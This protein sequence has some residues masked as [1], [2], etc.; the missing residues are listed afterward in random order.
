[1]QFHAGLQAL[2]AQGHRV[3]LEIGPTP[4]LSALGGKIA[5]DEARWLPSLRKGRPDWAQML[6]SLAALYEHGVTVN[7]AGFDRDY[8]RRR[9]SLPTYPFQRERHWMER[10][11]TPQATPATPAA[12]GASEDWLYEVRWRPAP[13]LRAA[14]T[15]LPSPAELAARV[16]GS[17]S[18]LRDPHGL[19]VYDEFLPALD[20][21]CVSYVTTAWRTL[22]WRPQLGQ[23]L[24]VTTLQETLGIVDAHCR[25]LGR[26]LEI[27]GEAGLLRRHGDAWEVVRIPAEEEPD[28]VAAGLLARFPSV[29]AEL[30][31]TRRCASQLPAVLR[32]A[33]DPLELLFPGGSL[34]MAER[35]Y[36]QA[37]AARAFNTLVSEVVRAAANGMAGQRPLRVL[38]I[39]AGTGGTTWHLLQAL[40]PDTEYVFTDVSP[41]FV[42]RAQEKFRDFPSV[43]YRSLDIERSPA[44]QGLAG[45]TFDIVVAANVLHATRDL[46]RTLSHAHRL[47]APGGL[48]VLLEA[49]ARQRFADLTV[50]LTDGWWRFTDTD[51]RP[52]Y[53]L[54]SRERWLALLDESGFVDSVALP[55]AAAADGGVLSQQSVLVS[56]APLGDAGRGAVPRPAAQAGQTWLVFADLGG[57]G[58]ALANR[59]RQRGERCVMITRG[60]R[61]KTLAPDL[62]QLAPGRPEDVTQL[63][64]EL[65]RPGQRA[66]RG[67]VH[68]W[69]LDAPLGE[70]LGAAELAEVQAAVCGTS[71]DVTRALVTAPGAAGSRLWLVTRGA[72][73]GDR[74]VG[75]MALAQ[76]PLWGLGRVI[77]LE[78]PEL[79]CVRID[80][81]PAAPDGE[82][83]ALLDEL[84][85]EAS[86]PEIALRAGGRLV[87]RLVRSPRG[88]QAPGAVDDPGLRP[89]A[90]YLITGGCGG[91]GLLVAR[92]MVDHGARHLVLVG[93]RPPTPEAQATID[94]MLAA[95]AEVRVRHADVARAE[96]MAGVLSEITRTMP[97]LHG[98]IH[99]AGVLD[100]GALLQQDWPRFARVL[101]PKVEGAWNLHTLTREMPLDFFILFSS[102]ASLL[103][104][105]GQ[106]NH[107][108]ANAFLDALAHHRRAQGQPAMSIGWGP[109]ADVGAW[110]RRRSDRPAAV[111]GEATI[112]PRAGLQILG[113]LMRRNPTQVGV[114]PVDWSVPSAGSERRAAFLAELLSPSRHQAR[115]VP[116]PSGPGIRQQILEAPA[117]TRWN[118]LH[119]LVRA[120]TVRVLGL[121]PRQDLDPAR[122]LSELGLDSLMAVELRNALGKALGVRLSATLLFT[123]PTV[124]RLVTY[125][126]GDV[127]GL[128]VAA[129]AT[130]APEPRPANGHPAASTAAELERLSSDDLAALLT[131]KLDRLERRGG[132]TA[133]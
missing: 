73:P 97:A 75:A 123:Y 76:A 13:P 7:W 56:R 65:A 1:V 58:Q 102:A 90:T 43:Q 26:M 64:D 79:G 117:G 28:A 42:A 23:R 61:S 68:L 93:R 33:C 44:E 17:A 132:S 49:T 106:G 25:L 124:D 121:G 128:D 72:Q 48:L 14:A 99:S 100:D 120:E 122:P 88:P 4:I 125:L 50:G 111:P 113:D 47:L 80:L 114:I 18:Q 119:E 66:L 77:A 30:G 92:W 94:A 129:T 78:H 115:G 95:G 69:A 101:A 15:M 81:D 130:D 91:L 45:T 40:P 60:P 131:E 24:S 107:A 127:L 9:M 54:I 51:V 108:A 20:D 105:A 52:S 103:G 8:P 133:R 31:M 83:P 104:S 55:A 112:S 85:G 63:I 84:F 96:E 109:W 22:G 57:V 11:R 89:G 41:L 29:E 12:S 74:P 82:A 32:G 5:D 53:A 46:R 110:A 35:L 62:R 6:E 16:G 87:P 67:V 71:L 86:E 70:H 27:L 36:Q 2:R 10:G 126:A 21:L 19:A 39:G 118:V 38:E 3:F 116:P 59:L 37:P 34:D 98:V